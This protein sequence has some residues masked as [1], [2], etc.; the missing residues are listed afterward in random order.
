VSLDV[1]QQENKPL[2][3]LCEGL[4]WHPSAKIEFPHHV[5]SEDSTSPHTIHNIFLQKMT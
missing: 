1:A 2:S 4:I 3:L 5:D